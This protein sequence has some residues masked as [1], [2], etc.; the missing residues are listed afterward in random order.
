MTDKFIL[1]DRK[2]ELTTDLA[3]WAKF[4]ESPDRIVARDTINGQDI[5]TVFLGSNHRYSSMEDGP[6]IV[7]ETMI[8]GGPNDEYQERCSTWEEAEAMHKRACKLAETG[9]E[10]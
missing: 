5:S 4:M 1:V 8:F 9:A 6:P 2:V 7:F 3:T 10:P